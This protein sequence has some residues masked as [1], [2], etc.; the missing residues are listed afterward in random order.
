MCSMSVV[1]FCLDHQ[2]FGCSSLV[3]SKIRPNFF[4]HK[5]TTELCQ[6][7]VYIVTSYYANDIIK[8]FWHGIQNMFNNFVLPEWFSNGSQLVCNLPNFLE[9]VGNDSALFH[10]QTV[11]F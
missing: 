2:S 9:K 1:A 6:R 10:S 8:T 5:N 7:R 11:E 3:G 4:M